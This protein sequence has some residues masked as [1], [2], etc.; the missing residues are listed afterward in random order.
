MSCNED[1]WG[2]Y[3]KYSPLFFLGIYLLQILD[4]YTL[5]R[6]LSLI[7]RICRVEGSNTVYQIFWWRPESSN[8]CTALHYQAEAR[9]P[10]DSCEAEVVFN[11]SS[12]LS[13]P[14]C[15]RQI[16]VSPLSASHSQKSLLHTPRRQWPWPCLLTEFMSSFFLGDWGWS[17]CMDC[18]FFCCSNIT[19]AGFICC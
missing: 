14:L 18:Y 12:V 4:N 16:S 9:F 6:V 5:W 17:N 8:L 13:A 10:L 11:A 1:L 2:I 15:R 7:D 3:R 19:E